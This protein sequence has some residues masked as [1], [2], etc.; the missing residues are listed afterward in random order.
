[1]G[2]GGGGN[3][4]YDM[5]MP[6]MAGMGMD[7]M[8]PGGRMDLGGHPAHYRGRYNSQPRPTIEVRMYRDYRHRVYFR[9][10][11]CLDF[12]CYHHDVK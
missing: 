8:G 3:Y 5:M 4:G 10:W 2:G 1:M 12:R 6:D 9:D 7:F 11:P